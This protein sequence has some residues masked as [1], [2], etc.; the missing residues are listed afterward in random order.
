MLKVEVDEAEVDEAEDEDEAAA[1]VEDDPVCAM[2]AVR[3]KKTNFWS[4]FFL[5]NKLEFN[6]HFLGKQSSTSYC[7]DKPKANKSLPTTLFNHRQKA[8]S[9]SKFEDSFQKVF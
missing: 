5:K 7:K 6:R 9:G 8:G 1:S 2:V 3:R 4:I